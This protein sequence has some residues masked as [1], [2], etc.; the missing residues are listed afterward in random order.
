MLKDQKLTIFKIRWNEGKD[1]SVTI[2][3]MV[4]GIISVK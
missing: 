4:F 1:L 2:H 3:L